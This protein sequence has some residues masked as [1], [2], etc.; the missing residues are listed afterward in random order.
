[1]A[2]LEFSLNL[3]SHPEELITCSMDYESYVDYLPDHIKRISIIETNS[4]ETI[5]EEEL[6]F[7]TVINTK[8]SQR[9]IHQKKDNVLSSQIIS[10]PF[11]DSTINVT[12]NATDSGTSVKV[13]ADLKLPLK[14]KILSIAIK[15]MYKL[16]L[17]G[18]LFKINNKI[19]NQKDN[20]NN[21]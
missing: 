15:K 6:E 16:V 14:Y 8:I 11:K 12:Y 21:E 2:N 10:G 17:R 18:V 5:T 4:N 1:M 3:S 19:I 9:S 13:V 20:S 7:H